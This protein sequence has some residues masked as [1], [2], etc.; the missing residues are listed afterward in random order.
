MVDSGMVDVSI[1]IQKAD[2]STLHAALNSLGGKT[3]R[4][5]DWLMEDD[6]VEEVYI[7]E[8]ELEKLLS[9]W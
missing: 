5:W 8:E 4:V 2:L 3:Q 1:D 7:S 9:V 6:S